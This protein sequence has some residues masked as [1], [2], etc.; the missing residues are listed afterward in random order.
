MTQINYNGPV[1]ELVNYLKN[2]KQKEELTDFIN[3]N[4][5][6]NDDSNIDNAF[7]NAIN[8]LKE[9]EDK[10]KLYINEIDMYK[11]LCDEILE[12]NKELLNNKELYP[13]FE[14]INKLENLLKE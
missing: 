2:L 6:N 5:K 7:Q 11:N 4:F 10:K 8:F 12:N 13:Y 14:E 9:Y 1:D 3:D